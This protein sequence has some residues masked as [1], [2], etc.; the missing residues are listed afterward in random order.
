MSND[1]R[2]SAEDPY[3]ALQSTPEFQELRRRFRGFVFPMTAFFLAW[4]FL[5]VLLSI[6]APGFMG[7]RVGGTITVGL[8][9]GLGQFVTTFAITLLYSRWAT[10]QL[11]PAADALG[12]RLDGVREH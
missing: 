8:L 4:Y 7:Q 6:F 3:L 9:F 1:A 2:T 5:Y 10:R 11:D 12:A